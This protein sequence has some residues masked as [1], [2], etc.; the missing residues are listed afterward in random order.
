MATCGPDGEK[1]RNPLLSSEL[2]DYNPSIHMPWVY[3]TYHFQPSSF[4]PAK[5]GKPLNLCL[6]RTREHEIEMQ[7]TFENIGT[8]P[9]L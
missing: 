5:K 1:G 7:E 8:K 6:P 3:P 9:L 2:F 4:S